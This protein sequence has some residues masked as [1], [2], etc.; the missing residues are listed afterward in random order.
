M[1]KPAEQ[2]V[3]DHRAGLGREDGKTNQNKTE[4]GDPNSN[5]TTAPDYHWENLLSGLFY[6]NDKNT[7]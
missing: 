1:T 3:G 7:G 6:C 5:P 4:A 2:C